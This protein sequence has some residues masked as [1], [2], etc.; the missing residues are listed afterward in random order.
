MSVEVELDGSGAFA[1][2]KSNIGTYSYTEASTPVIPG[3]D[4][5]GVGEFT[6]EVME[7]VRR[8]QLLYRDNIVL[9]DSEY[10]EVTGFISGVSADNGIARV[11]GLSRLGSL[12]TEATIPA[13]EGTLGDLLLLIFQRGNIVDDID[14]EDDVADR[15]IV[16]PGFTGN[17]WIFLKNICT[18]QQIEVSLV[19]NRVLVRKLRQRELRQEG[20]ASEFWSIEDVQLAQNIEV[21]YYN[22]QF[23]EDFLAYPKGGWNPDI[24]VYQVDANEEVEL[25]VSIDAYLLDVEQPEIRDFVGIFEEDSVYSVSG[26]DGLPVPPQLW[27]DRGGS[28]TVSLAENG[29][30]LKVRIKGPNLPSLAPFTIGLSDGANQY[31]TLRLR[32]RGVA[33]DEQVVTVP[34]GLTDAETSNEIGQTINNPMISTYEEAYTA[35]VRARQIFAS[36]QRRINL[37]GRQLFD[38]NQSEL[39]ITNTFGEFDELLIPQGPFLTLDDPF[40]GQLDVNALSGDDYFFF[41]FDQEFSSFTFDDLDAFNTLLVS[42]SFG[43]LSGSRVRY[44][45]S[46]MR[47]READTSEARVDVVAEF[48]TLVSDFNEENAGRTF[49]DFQIAF[50]DLSFQDFSLIPLRTDTTYPFFR[51][52]NEEVGILDLNV[53]T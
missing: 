16:Y 25:D 23:F 27:L 44:R 14:I 20:I 49:D 32:G 50:Y 7:D 33:F 26:N 43:S 22:Y 8:S 17:M 39:P 9:R 15:F 29:S 18:A 36:P 1:G 35:G 21:V 47:V 34:T 19:L 41:D 48:D 53:L 42:Q 51:L 2:D 45:E 11:T 30:V 46:Y 24:P 38:P 13:G 6:F 52:D 5:G 3:D 31:S 12:N 37:T 28:L 10:G 40:L 4:S